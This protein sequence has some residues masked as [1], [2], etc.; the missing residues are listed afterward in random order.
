[1]KN[2]ITNI[3]NSKGFVSIESI[4]VIGVIVVLAGIILFFFNGK[5][6]DVSNTSGGQIAEA[7]ANQK[8]SG[9]FTPTAIPK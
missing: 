5:A 4:L 8:A 3:R 2:V 1:M 6:Q 7:E 9:S